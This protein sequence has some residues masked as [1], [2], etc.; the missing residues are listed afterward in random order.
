MEDEEKK[1]REKEE[2]LNKIREEECRME[3]LIARTV[4]IERRVQIA[5][6]HVIQS[7]AENQNIYMVGLLIYN[8][9]HSKLLYFMLVHFTIW[10]D[11]LSS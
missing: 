1:K 10:K 2:E 4:A 5:P 7:L 11:C 6:T 8:V 9:Q 3:A